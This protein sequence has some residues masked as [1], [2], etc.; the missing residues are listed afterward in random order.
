MGLDGFSGSRQLSVALS[1][2][3]WAWMC[4]EL[5]RLAR[6]D[7]GRSSGFSVGVGGF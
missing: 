4:L 7:F 1:G 2:I 3:M 6:T 5:S